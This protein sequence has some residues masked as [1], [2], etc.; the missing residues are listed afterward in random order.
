VR[1][2]CGVPIFHTYLGERRV[3]NQDRRRPAE[4]R[5]PSAYHAESHRP[6]RSHRAAGARIASILVSIRPPRQSGPCR[7]PLPD[8][9]SR[10]G[11][12]HRNPPK[13]TED[14]PNVD[15]ANS[16]SASRDSRCSIPVCRIYPVGNQ[17]EC[18]FRQMHGSDGCLGLPIGGGQD[19]C[20][21]VQSLPPME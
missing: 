1:G 21:P 3:A 2:S 15:L 10:P 5:E 9:G 18:A 12:D 11:A 16:A 14:S 19:G 7:S 8:Q 17:R 20:T 6:A 13:P 4:E